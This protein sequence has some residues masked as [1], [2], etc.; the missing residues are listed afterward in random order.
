M[1]RT[2]PLERPGTRISRFQHTQTKMSLAFN[3][4]TMSEDT[5]SAATETFVTSDLIRIAHLQLKIGVSKT[6][7]KA[8]WLKLK[9]RKESMSC[10]QVKL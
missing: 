3:L 6:P 8:K 1:S 2:A 9:E 7:I 10:Y 4:L 5:K